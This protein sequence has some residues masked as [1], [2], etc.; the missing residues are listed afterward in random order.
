MASLD[1]ILIQ[2]N[3]LMPLNQNLKKLNKSVHIDKL[4][5]YF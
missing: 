1:M 5:D 3:G 4:F 2:K